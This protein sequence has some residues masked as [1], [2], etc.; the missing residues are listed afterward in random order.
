MIGI[1]S[2]RHMSGCIRGIEAQKTIFYHNLWNFQSC[3]VL[4]NLRISLL[5]IPQNR[6]F[7]FCA[8]ITLNTS[9]N[10]LFLILTI[11]IA[12]LNVNFRPF[13]SWH[14]SYI[15]S[16]CSNSKHQNPAISPP[17]FAKP[18]FD[19]FI[20]IQTAITVSTTSATFE[21]VLQNSHH[22][23]H[24]YHP[25]SCPWKISFSEIKLSSPFQIAGDPFRLQGTS[26][27]QIAG[28][29]ALWLVWPISEIKSKASKAILC[30]LPKVSCP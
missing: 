21:I 6:K 20:H 28:D 26:P 4:A 11:S 13:F 1:P 7:V 9:T 8:L 15:Y 19:L 14:Y 27:F 3:K 24:P 2:R 5:Q 29:V 16:I 12:K 23:H 17:V 25:Q 22:S 30:R 10:H 18:L